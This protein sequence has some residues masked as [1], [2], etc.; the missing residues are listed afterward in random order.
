[1][2]DKLVRIIEG[3][4]EL[5]GRNGIR[6]V[7]MDD[8]SRHLGISKKTTYQ[9]VDNKKDLLLKISEYFT[10]E[11]CKKMEEIASKRLNAIDTLL[12]ISQILYQHWQKFKPALSFEMKKYY[13]EISEMISETNY[14]YTYQGVKQN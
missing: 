13:P 4:A 5:F 9:Y 7:S 2:E 12:E 11:F 6:C 10:A 1:M 8:I 14:K 3:A